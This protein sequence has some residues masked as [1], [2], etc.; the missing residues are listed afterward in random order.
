[1]HHFGAGHSSV[2]ETNLSVFLVGQGGPGGPGY[3]WHYFL[4][5][6]CNFCRPDETLHSLYPLRLNIPGNTRLKNLSAIKHERYRLLC[7]GKWHK[8]VK[9]K[10]KCNIHQFRMCLSGR[11]TLRVA[12]EIYLKELARTKWCWAMSLSYWSR[13]LGASAGN[14]PNDIPCQIHTDSM[15]GS[16]P[17]EMLIDTLKLQGGPPAGP[18]HL[19]PQEPR[20]IWDL[21]R[22]C[23]PHLTDFYLS[24][25]MF[26]P[27]WLAVLRRDAKKVLSSFHPGLCGNATTSHWAKLIHQDQQNGLCII[28]NSCSKCINFCLGVYSIPR[29]TKGRNR[30][31]KWTQVSNGCTMLLAVSSLFLSPAAGFL[32][33]FLAWIRRLQAV[34]NCWSADQCPCST[35]Q[36]KAHWRIFSLSSPGC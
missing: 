16:S 6:C 23:W 15:L 12:T 13:K 2:G 35:S 26:I 30:V 28:C 1:M 24:S 31:T 22:V 4:C 9:S 8:A 19:K 17:R 33:F 21:L 14:H 18:W 20:A 5:W 10:W 27:F 11:E 32:P 3:P 29:F 7:K 36:C 34:R 25:V